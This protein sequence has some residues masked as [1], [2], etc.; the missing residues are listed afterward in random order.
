MNTKNNPSIFIVEDN[1]M[2]AALLKRE[3]EKNNYNNI[4]TFSTGEECLAHLSDCPDIILLDHQLEGQLNGID[5]LRKIKSLNRNIKTIFLTAH[6]K[7]DLALDALRNG[8]YDYV[9]KN[10]IAFYNVKIMINNIWQAL[11]Q[12]R[13]ERIARRFQYGILSSISVI[14]VFS[15][16]LQ[17]NYPQ[18]ME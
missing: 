1:T 15:L 9:I 16:W 5:V 12:F 4:S 6:T 11:K 13:E 3:L 8:A 7:L 2:Y 17:M 10:E 14:A 18:L